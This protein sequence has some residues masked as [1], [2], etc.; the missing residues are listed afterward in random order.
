MVLHTIIVHIYL[1]VLYSGH[2]HGVHGS[3]EVVVQLEVQQ[4]CKE[5]R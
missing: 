3:L 5:V 1:S 4:L 2:L